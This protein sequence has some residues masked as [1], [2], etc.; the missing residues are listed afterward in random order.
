MFCGH[1]TT[2]RSANPTSKSIECATLCLKRPNITNTAGMQATRRAWAQQRTALDRARGG[3]Q[4]Q[5]DTRAAAS[6]AFGAP[7]PARYLRTAGSSFHKSLDPGK[8]AP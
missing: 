4:H 6:P 2:A 7:M 1:P 3:A 5:Q 8:N